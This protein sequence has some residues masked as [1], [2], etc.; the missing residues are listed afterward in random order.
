MKLHALTALRD[1]ASLETFSKS[2]RSPIGYETFIRHIVEAGHPKEA[3][4]YVPKCDGPKRAEMYALC[5]E[6]RMAGNVCKER[7]DKKA[8]E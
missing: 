4:S 3:V 1:F 2:K 5:G 8:L 6:W 7:G